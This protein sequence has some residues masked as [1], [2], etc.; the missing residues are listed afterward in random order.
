MYRSNLAWLLVGAVT[1]GCGSSTSNVAQ[2][3][4]N[5][6]GGSAGNSSASGSANGGSSGN[7]GGN[8]AAAGQSASGSGG[9]AGSSAAAVGDTPAEACIAY[10]RAVCD[11]LVGCQGLSLSACDYAIKDCPDVYFSP[12]STRTVAGLKACALEYAARSCADVLSRRT[13]ACTT[14]G[15]RQP[16]EAC[17]YPSQCASLACSASGGQCGTCL[18]LATEG[19]A[20]AAEGP[21][22]DSG[23]RCV[24]AKCAPGPSEAPAAPG[25]PCAQRTICQGGFCN[26]GGI[27]QL[28]GE[29]G[30]SCTSSRECKPGLFCDDAGLVCHPPAAMGEPC[31]EETA[32]PFR[33]CA[34]GACRVTAPPAIGS[35]GAYAQIG[36]DCSLHIGDYIIDV[37]CAPG[38]HCGAGAKC[39]ANREMG[40][41]CTYD[42][43]CQAGL[44]CLCPANAPGPDCTAHICGKPGFKGDPCAPDGNP[45]HPAFA[46]EGNQCVPRMN[47]GL[48]EQTC[49]P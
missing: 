43:E 44:T 37:D 18:E 41:A 14:P 38:S 21:E 33:H 16:G 5:S 27:C 8:N 39:A 13:L 7:L 19:Q 42:L 23:L 3:G 20:C 31:V 36:E 9:A 45:C 48:F 35:C 46:C 34:G 6:T 26:A 15:T 12:G 40:S 17:T 28:L 25:Q 32:T 24:D 10:A 1:W 22:C 11:R 29:S 47:R 4:G 49:Q 2:T 30:A